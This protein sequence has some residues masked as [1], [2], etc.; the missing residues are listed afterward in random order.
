MLLLTPCIFLVIFGSIIMAHSL[1]PP[2]MY[3]PLMPFAAFATTLLS[4]VGLVGNQFGF[5]RGGFRVFVLCPAR[6][7]DILLGKNLALAP[8]A[9]GLGLGMTLLVQVMYPMRFDHFVAAGPQLLSMYLLFCLLANCL[10]LLAPMP[11]AAGSL[12][13][14]NPK[15]VPILLQVAFVFLFPLALTPTLLPLGVE[16]ILAQWLEWAQAIP[17]DLLLSLGEGVAVVYFYRFVLDVQGRWLHA[18]EQK[19]LEL[20]TSK[21]E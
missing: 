13:P 9:L 18:R 1:E 12:K 15:L 4:M 2:E 5:D 21:V 16:F 14:A 11:I 20:V 6:R 10:S 3:R 17:V 19:I 8:L 7:R